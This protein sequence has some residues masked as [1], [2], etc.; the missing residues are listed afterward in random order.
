MF[1]QRQCQIQQR[2]YVTITPADEAGNTVVVLIV[3]HW[4]HFPQAYAAKD[5]SA[6]TVASILFK[7]IC[8]FGLFDE[9]ASDPGSAFLSEVVLHLLKWLGVK[10]KISL[11]QR[12]ESNGCEAS[13]REF[14]RHLRTLVLDERIK[15]KWSSDTVLP[16]I[17]FHLASY[18][19][20]ETGGINPFHLKYGTQ[21]AAYFCLPSSLDSGTASIEFLKRLNKDLSIIREI[22]QKLQDDIVKKRQADNGAIPI[23]LPGDFILWNSREN[24]CDHLPEKLTT[25]WKGPYKVI[26][27]KKNDIRCT[28]VVL[29]EEVILHVSRVKPFFGSTEDATRVAMSDKDQVTI[30]S[31]NW[32]TGNP[33]I[34][35]SMVFGITWEDGFQSIQYNPDLAAS[36]PF[37][38]YVTSKPRLFPLQFTSKEAK[39]EITKINKNGITSLFV[40]LD[41]HY[42]DGYN[43]IWYDNLSLPHPEKTYVTRAK[44][45]SWVSQ[46]HNKVKIIVPIFN[47]HY[48]LTTY[49]VQAYISKE[50]DISSMVEVTMN[51]RNILPQIWTI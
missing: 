4:S 49:E 9:I 14:I 5:Y 43:S 31:I 36:K 27:Q 20:S 41:L 12:H 32:S 33:H 1:R 13:G 22:S 2:S 42:F 28:H 38:D 25:A 30:I 39:K 44:V 19:T 6:E 47:E 21:D 35:T 24:P 11:V 23:Y 37:E 16:L 8:T 29:G 51:L 26:E 46:S 10:H 48:V 18:P 34:R 17:N 45:I 3:E 50:I 15:K 7:H 40:Y